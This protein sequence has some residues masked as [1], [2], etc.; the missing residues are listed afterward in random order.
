MVWVRVMASGLLKN[1]YHLSVDSRR[2][3]ALTAVERRLRKELFAIVRL[4]YAHN[5]QLRK[6]SSIIWERT[7]SSSSLNFKKSG[8]Q[9]RL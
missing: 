6:A 3:L 1:T 8:S 9:A 2:P 7:E 4:P 5:A